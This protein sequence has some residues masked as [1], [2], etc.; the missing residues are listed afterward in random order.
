MEV[1]VISNQVCNSQTFHFGARS[2]NGK[3]KLWLQSV[4]AADGDDGGRVLDL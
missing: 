3:V 4:I 1:S 2:T